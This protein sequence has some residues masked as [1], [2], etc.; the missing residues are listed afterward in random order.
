MNKIYRVKRIEKPIDYIYIN[1]YTNP[2]TNKPIWSIIVYL[3]PVSLGSIGYI[4]N[5]DKS[6]TLCSQNMVFSLRDAFSERS[7]SV[8]VNA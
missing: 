4:Q 3:P 5:G 6:M 7:L 1:Q 8:D 2:I